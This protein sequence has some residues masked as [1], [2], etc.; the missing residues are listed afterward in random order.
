M[1]QQNTVPT[2][3]PG[4]RKLVPGKKV[5]PEP[6]YAP[7]PPPGGS[8]GALANQLKGTMP[9]PVMEGDASGAVMPEEEGNGIPLPLAMTLDAGIKNTSVPIRWR[10][11]MEALRAA[12]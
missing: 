12:K 11:A 5:E 7:P 9:P 6:V 1:G 2:E 3:I 8:L 4:Q 10:M